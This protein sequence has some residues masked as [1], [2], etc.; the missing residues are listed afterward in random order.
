MLPVSQGQDPAKGSPKDDLIRD[1]QLPRQP[2]QRTLLR[3]VTD[4]PVL[5]VWEAGL[6]SR[7]GAQA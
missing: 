4:E 5:G 6:K 3:T 2:L 7:K 1:A